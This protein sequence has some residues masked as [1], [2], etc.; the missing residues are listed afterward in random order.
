MGLAT[1]AVDAG[2]DSVN[3]LMTL[4]VKSRPLNFQEHR[5][6]LLHTTATVSLTFHCRMQGGHPRRF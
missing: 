6:V 2:G 4:L 5:S 1:V 3:E